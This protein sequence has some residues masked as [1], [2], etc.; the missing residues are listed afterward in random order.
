[1]TCSRRDFNGRFALGLVG[2]AVA[3]C[4]GPVETPTSATECT[5]PPVDRDGWVT[6][7][8]DDHPA[9]REPGGS[10]VILDPSSLL[11]VVVIHRPDGCFCAVW[12]ICTHGACQVEYRATTRDLECPCHGSRFDEQGRVL[13]GPATEPLRAF[14]VA[15]D[16][17]TILIRRR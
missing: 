10:A 7:S 8:L 3:R 4:G 1:M 9:L 15:R 13:Q 2:I 6:V 12:S 16:G 11:D 17:D 14:E 5:T